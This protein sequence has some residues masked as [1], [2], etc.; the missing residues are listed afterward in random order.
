MLSIPAEA[1]ASPCLDQIEY[2]G[3]TYVRRPAEPP[4]RRQGLDVGK[5][6]GSGKLL[7]CNAEGDTPGGEPSTSSSVP[8]SVHRVERLPI[9]DA[10]ASRGADGQLAL[11]RARVEP[12]SVMVPDL[13]ASAIMRRRSVPISLS[14][15]TGLRDV[16][17]EVRQ[18]GVA[19]LRGGRR[20]LN[21]SAR[22]E[23]SLRLVKNGKIEAGRRTL[24]I[25][26][27]T[28]AGIRVAAYRWLFVRPG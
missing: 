17:I 23:V 4:L 22:A 16:Q 6:V 15:I 25:A 26:A 18:G 9:T 27:R 19:I 12:I 14:A 11:F 13:T 10:L 7:I 24:T 5:P 8:V 2:E 20:Q 3:H 21:A 1:V 28:P